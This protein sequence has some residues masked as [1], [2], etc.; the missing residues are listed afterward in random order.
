MSRT[1]TLNHLPESG[2]IDCSRGNTLNIERGGRNGKSAALTGA[3]DRKVSTVPFG[4]FADD[5]YTAADAVRQNSNIIFC[6]S[7]IE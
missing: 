6:S 3:A 7:D 2:H 5:F 4:Q 1:H